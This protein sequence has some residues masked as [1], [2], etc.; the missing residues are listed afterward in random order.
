MAREQ[1]GQFGQGNPKQG[2]KMPGQYPQS[3]EQRRQ[4]EQRDREERSRKGEADEE[5]EES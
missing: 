4:R 3:E 2:G 1:S 5:E